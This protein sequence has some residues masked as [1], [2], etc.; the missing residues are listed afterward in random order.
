LD[1]VREAPFFRLIAEEH[2]GGSVPADQIDTVKAAC[3]TL[4]VELRQH[5]GRV[6]FWRNRPAQDRLRG[7]VVSHLDDYNAAPFEKLQIIADRVMQLARAL[8]TRL[9]A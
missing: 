4:V 8:H 1:T 9:A 6:D 2:D 5:L 3:R 7:W